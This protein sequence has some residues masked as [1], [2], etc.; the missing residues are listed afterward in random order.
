MS[1][2]YESATS[3]T[4]AL[5]EITK[6]L[7]QTGASEYGSSSTSD[8]QVKVTFTLHGQ[9]Y[10]VEADGAGWARAWLKANPYTYRKR[11]TKDEYEKKALVQ[12]HL[13]AFSI[14]RDWLKAQVAVLQ[15]EVMTPEELF[16]AHRVAS[17]GQRVI[18]LARGAGLLGHDND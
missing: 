14:V 3:G 6:L 18:D 17:N 8:G 1:L 10:C 9:S 15:T 7:R 5:T 11:G 2:P 16:L 12:G 13:A 4:A